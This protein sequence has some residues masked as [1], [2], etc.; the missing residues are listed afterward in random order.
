MISI[1]NYNDE[2]VSPRKTLEVQR[3][4][5]TKKTLD[6]LSSVFLILIIHRYY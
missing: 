6:Q 4:P 5:V 2:F 1:H 3:E